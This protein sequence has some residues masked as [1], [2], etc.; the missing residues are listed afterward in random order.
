[1][2]QGAIVVISRRTRDLEFG[3]RCLIFTYGACASY[4]RR[5][6]G[7]GKCVVILKLNLRVTHNPPLI[8][9]IH[10]K[11]SEPSLE[12]NQKS[13]TTAFLNTKCKELFYEIRIIFS[14]FP[15]SSM[16]WR[17]RAMRKSSAAILSAPSSMNTFGSRLSSWYSS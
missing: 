12:G 6:V 1:M 9:R 17:R 13:P 15:S 2:Q 8:R 14:V 3:T 5:I 16:K 7:P 10:P 11:N 4:D